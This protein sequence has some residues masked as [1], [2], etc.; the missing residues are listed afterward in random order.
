MTSLGKKVNFQVSTRQLILKP[1]ETI[2]NK[3]KLGITY[4]TWQFN[5][6]QQRF[7]GVGPY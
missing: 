4:Q 2:R 3:K 5:V 6:A 7:L 1:G